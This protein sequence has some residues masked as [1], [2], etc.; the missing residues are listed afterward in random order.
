[1][2]TPAERQLVTYLASVLARDANGNLPLLL[3]VGA[4]RSLS[5]E[6]QLIERGI[7]FR[8]DRVDVEPCHVEHPVIGECQTCSVTDLS[9]LAGSHYRAALANFVL[10]HVENIEQAAKEIYRVLEPAGCFVATIPNPRAPEFLLSHYTPL[11]FH[12]W[13]RGGSG[14]ETHYAYKNLDTLRKIFESA[15]FATQ[16]VD[17]FACISLYTEPFAVLRWMGRTYDALISKMRLSAL[18]GNVCVVFRKPSLAAQ[19]RLRGDTPAA[20]RC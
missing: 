3:N 5:I 11:A 16:A 12:R 13:V 15:G 18:M 17:R 2:Q 19:E 10:E 9:P 4:G 6:E 20:A 8:C 14:W 1:M 7:R